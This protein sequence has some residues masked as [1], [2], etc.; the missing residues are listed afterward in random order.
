MK[1]KT[2]VIRVMKGEVK[3]I[4]IKGKKSDVFKK[5]I[6]GLKAKKSVAAEGGQK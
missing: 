3:K 5:Y 4:T 1:K 2:F 6:A